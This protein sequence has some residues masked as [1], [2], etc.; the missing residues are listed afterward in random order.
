MGNE[1]DFG[2]IVRRASL[3]RPDRAGEMEGCAKRGIRSGKW[4]AH[5]RGA[6]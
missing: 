2:K 4:F 6:V 1:R 5:R 3:F